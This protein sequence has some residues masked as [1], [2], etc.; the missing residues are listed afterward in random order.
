MG[1]AKVVLLFKVLTVANFTP[2]AYSL[3]SELLPKFVTRTDTWWAEAQ[4]VCIRL[5]LRTK[6]GEHITGCSIIHVRVSSLY[7]FA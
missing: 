7:Y 5:N 1:F 2:P 4:Y 6:L 3:A